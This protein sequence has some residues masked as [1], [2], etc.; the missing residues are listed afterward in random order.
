MTLHAILTERELRRWYT[1]Y[2]PAVRARC[3]GVCGNEA[4]ADEAL[5]ET[6]IRAWR[7]RG[8][9]DG[10]NPLGWLQTIGR[11]ASLDILRKRRP[12]ASDPEQWLAMPATD[13]PPEVKIDLGKLLDTVSADDA[14]AL[15]LRYAEEWSLREL[16][17]HLDTSPR[18][19][20]RRLE[21]LMNRA[22]A[23]LGVST[24]APDG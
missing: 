12:W 17:E 15:R 16:A 21:R 10:R 20:R 11:N 7:A 2:G 8:T 14:A 23:I 19:L 4:D 24:E 1:V 13:S 3:R 22:R 18:T 5:Q 9:F 6:F